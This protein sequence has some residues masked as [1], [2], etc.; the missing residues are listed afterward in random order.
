MLAYLVKEKGLQIE[1][2][3]LETQACY[4]SRERKTHKWYLWLLGRIIFLPVFPLV[5]V[6]DS[7][8]SRGSSSKYLFRALIE[9]VNYDTFTASFEL[10]NS[11]LRLCL[12][13]GLHLGL[14]P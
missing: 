9:V 1:E 12:A 2:G 7:C 5:V 13:Q 8:L 6:A 11:K 4:S 10:V 3:I 14:A